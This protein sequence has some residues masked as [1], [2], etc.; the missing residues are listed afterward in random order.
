MSHSSHSSHSSHH[1]VS[2]QLRNSAIFYSCIQKYLYT[3]PAFFKHSNIPR[4]PECTQNF[5]YTFELSAL[6]IA[7]VYKNPCIHCA[8]SPLS[9][10]LPYLS[11]ECIHKYLYTPLPAFSPRFLSPLSLPAFSPR[12]LS[13]LSLPAFSPRFLSPLSLPAFRLSP[14]VLFSGCIHKYADTVMHG[15][16]NACILSSALRHAFYRGCQM[17][18]FKIKENA[19]RRTLSAQRHFPSPLQMR[20]GCHCTASKGKL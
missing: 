13:P 11:L 4:R 1:T 6:Q 8:I 17:L 9:P 3:S 7:Q 15:Y 12:F 2:L 5:N 16:M 20:S 14:P 19:A 18:C 10:V